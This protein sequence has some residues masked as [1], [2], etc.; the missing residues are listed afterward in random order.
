MVQRTELG[1]Q[2]S[3]SAAKAQ[4]KPPMWKV[5]VPIVIIVAAVGWTAFTLLSSPSEEVV[6]PKPKAIVS[7]ILNSIG[8]REELLEHVRVVVEGDDPDESKRTVRITGT[9]KNKALLDELE[10]I[11]KSAAGDQPVVFEVKVK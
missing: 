8:D 3:S 10:L 2:P 1:E 11:V 4:S 9:V 6:S 7:T 5:A